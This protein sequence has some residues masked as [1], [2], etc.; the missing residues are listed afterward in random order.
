MA[1]PNGRCTAIWKERY[2]SVLENCCRTWHSP[3][4]PISYQLVCGLPASCCGKISNQFR[5]AGDSDITTMFK[6]NFPYFVPI[7]TSES[8][9]DFVHWWSLDQSIGLSTS[10]KVVVY[11]CGGTSTPSSIARKARFSPENSQEHDCQPAT[12]TASPDSAVSKA[13]SNLHVLVLILGHVTP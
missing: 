12:T 4:L 1:S 7:S 8:K 10:I 9:L 5:M 13:A 11:C 3:T 2:T 6:H